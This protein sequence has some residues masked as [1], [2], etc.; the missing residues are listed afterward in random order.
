[1]FR[2]F[3]F[4]CIDSNGIGRQIATSPNSGVKFSFYLHFL[5]CQS[6]DRKSGHSTFIVLTEIEFEDRYLVHQI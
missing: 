5:N 6:R 3:V 2:V 1:M 4:H